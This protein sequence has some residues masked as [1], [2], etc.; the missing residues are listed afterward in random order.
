MRGPYNYRQNL[1]VAAP[2][3]AEK[4]QRRTNLR[5]GTE[6]EDKKKVL[7]EQQIQQRTDH[8]LKTHTE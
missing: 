5:S 2:H 3:R 8:Q 1:S 4:L 6:R 7:D